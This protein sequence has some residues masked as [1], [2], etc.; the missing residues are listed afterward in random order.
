[1]VLAARSGRS[2]DLEIVV[3]GHQ[4]AVLQR[5][6]K[7][8]RLNEADRSLLAA[9]LRVLPRA[10][11]QGWLVT[12]DTLLRTGGSSPD[13]GPSRPDGPTGPSLRTTEIRTLVIGMARNP[14]WGY[15]RIAG[16]LACGCR[17]FG[18]AV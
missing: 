5:A 8:S 17:I 11:R 4:L 18:R 9:I 10:R 14:T 3:L 12:P 6:V 13:I 2:K 1:M 7:P 15:R 16:E